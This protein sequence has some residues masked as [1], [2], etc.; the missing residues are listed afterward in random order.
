MEARANFFLSY[1]ATEKIS[2]RKLREAITD[3]FPGVPL[4]NVNI[5]TQIAC[6]G[7]RAQKGDVVSFLVDGTMMVGELL[8]T[9]GVDDGNESI[10][11]SVI[12]IWRFLSRSAQWV[13]FD[14]LREGD[15]I[16]IIRTD[17]SLRGVHVHRM[18]RDGNSCLVHLPEGCK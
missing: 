2:S 11:Y 16:I 18:A 13:D 14:T 12:A 4:E 5:H 3:V 10:M 1:E 8:V 6:M 7:G 9:V 17:E 15:E